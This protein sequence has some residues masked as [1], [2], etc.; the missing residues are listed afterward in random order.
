MSMSPE[1]R[2]RIF[3]DLHP[4][5]IFSGHS[6]VAGEQKFEI[7]EEEEEEKEGGPLDV[8]DYT[9]PTCNYRIEVNGMGY[10][11]ALLGKKAYISVCSQLMSLL[12][13]LIN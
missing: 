13:L 5:V 12:I 1:A 8:T 9:V 11:A 10:G 3:K 2:Q 4:R 7:E 6:N